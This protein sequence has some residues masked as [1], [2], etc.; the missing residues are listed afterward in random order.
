MLKGNLSKMKGSLRNI[1]TTEVFDTCKLLPRPVDSSGLV[2]TKLK[3]K[4]EYR[5]HVFLEP[6]RS[7]FVERFLNFLKSNNSLYS[8]IEI[9]LNNDRSDLSTNEYSNFILLELSRLQSEQL[10]IIRKR[11]YNNELVESTGSS[12]SKAEERC[13]NN[14]DCSWV[15]SELVN[16]TSKPMESK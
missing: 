16:C 2:I 1:P 9:S 6:V 11:D 7:V 8:D 14:V 5:S 4:V 13:Y 10:E 3:R 12:T 15:V